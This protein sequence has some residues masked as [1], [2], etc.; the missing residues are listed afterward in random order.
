MKNDRDFSFITVN[1]ENDEE[2]VIQAG[3]P[4][5]PVN[6]VAQD[7]AHDVLDESKEVQIKKTEAPQISLEKESFEKENV[8]QKE[9][10]YRGVTEADLDDSGPFQKMRLII[11]ICGLLLL[12]GFIVY[13]V[14][15][16]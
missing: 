4:K 14:F 3:V 5:K 9:E 8:G 15:L 16:R 6:D 7:A 2:I 10:V 11:L 12:A 13:F 1:S